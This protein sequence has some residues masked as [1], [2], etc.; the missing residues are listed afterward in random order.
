MASINVKIYDHEKDTIVEALR[1]LKDQTVSVSYI[2]KQ[3]GFNPNRTRF[4]LEE[5]LEEGRIK[6]IPTKSFNA[7]YVRYK[8]EV[9]K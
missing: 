6:K 5:L 3:V 1:K 2:A 8:Y 4:I 9:V 7:R